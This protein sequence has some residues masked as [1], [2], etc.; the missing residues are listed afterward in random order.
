MKTL[1]D[2]LRLSGDEDCGVG[3]I[4]RLC[5]SGMPVAYYVGID[6]TAYTNSTVVVVR[7]IV[8][9]MGAGINHLRDE[10]GAIFHQTL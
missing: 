5:D 2:F 4:C 10:H 6:D 3:M 8:E 1:D 7:S 9:L